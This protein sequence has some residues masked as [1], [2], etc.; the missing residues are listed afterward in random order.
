MHRGH[1]SEDGQIV[2]SAF[3]GVAIA[4]QARRRM[5]HAALDVPCRDYAARVQAATRSATPSFRRRHAAALRVASA[6]PR[7]RWHIEQPLHE[8]P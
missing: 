6:A 7:R 3:A 1:M 5:H 2:R 4:K 8:A